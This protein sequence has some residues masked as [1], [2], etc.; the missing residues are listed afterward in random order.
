M[1]IDSFGYENKNKQNIAREQC[2]TLRNDR[3]GSATVSLYGYDFKVREPWYCGGSIE[4]NCNADM[5]YGKDLD[6]IADFN[7]KNL[8]RFLKDLSYLRDLAEKRIADICTTEGITEIHAKRFK[9]GNKKLCRVFVTMYDLLTDGYS[10]SEIVRDKILEEYIISDTL[11]TQT[12]I[13]NKIKELEEKYGVKC[14]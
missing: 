3:N 14:Q 8:E 2:E 9:E 5:L 13:E 4:T 7:I 12:E 11:K 1:L 6:I 10:D